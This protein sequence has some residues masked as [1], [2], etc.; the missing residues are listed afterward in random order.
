MYVH[1]VLLLAACIDFTLA[2][3]ALQSDTQS[4]TEKYSVVL[5]AAV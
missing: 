4:E 2:D 3:Q 1:G 5:L